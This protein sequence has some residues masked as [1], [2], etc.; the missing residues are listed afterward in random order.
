M[1]LDA[2]VKVL[3][4]IIDWA[5]SPTRRAELHQMLDDLRATPAVTDSETVTDPD[6]DP[7]PVGAPALD[8]T[9]NP[10]GPVPS[11]TD[12]TNGDN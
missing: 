12:S 4:E 11:G 3:D 6:P 2:V 7:H 1:E 10:A 8:P 9:V 5:M